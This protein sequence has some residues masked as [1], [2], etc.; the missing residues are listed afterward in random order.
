MTHA[1][2]ATLFLACLAAALWSSASAKAQE[3]NGWAGVYVSGALSSSSFK[4]SIDSLHTYSP[5]QFP[6]SQYSSARK[7]GL[8]IQLGKNWT[9]DRVLVGLE[10]EY[11]PSKSSKTVCRGAVDITECLTDFEGYLNITDAIALQGSAKVRLG[12]TFDK[13]M[14]YAAAG[15][16]R[17]KHTSTLDVVCPYGCGFSDSLGYT[18]VTTVTQNETRPVFG[19]GL[20]YQ[21]GRRWNVGADYQ[22]LKSGSLGQSQQKQASYGV[23]DISSTGS[24]VLSRLQLRLIYRF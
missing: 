6:N 5:D 8:S 9:W 20:E 14:L 4:H 10:L 18:R 22:Y 19:V 3:A 17:L 13:L 1:N 2:R 11:D 15:Y 24:T 7:P 16:A 21:V 12:Y 23:Q